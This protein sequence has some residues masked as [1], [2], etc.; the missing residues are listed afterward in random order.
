MNMKQPD[1]EH[2]EEMLPR[3]YDG[4]LTREECRQVEIWMAESEANRRIAGQVHILCLATD[5]MRVR[6]KVN[7]E[8]ALDKVRARMVARKTTW[9]E[10]AQRAAAV[11]FVPLVVALFVQYMN[12]RSP[13]AQM[14]EV[15]TNP[16]V[17]TSVVLP[18][19]TV[20]YLNS[21]SSLSYPSRF[22]GDTREVTLK[23]EAYFDVAKD[24]KKKFIVSTAHR[25]KIEVLGTHFNVEAYGDDAD[26]STTLVE[27]KVCFLY[28]TKNHAGRK[29]V[30][31]PGQ[32]LVYNP[33]REDVQLYATSGVTET[34][35][36]DG[37]I[38]FRNTPLPEALRM[39]EK[40]FNVDFIVRSK[41]LRKNAFTGVFTDQRLERILEYFKISS[42]IRWR[43]L[44]SA[45]IRDERSKIEIY[46]DQ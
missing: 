21:R 14:M 3:Y 25:S 37:K 40:R 33:A 45:D 2:I 34:A 43:Y 1:R 10:W 32:K 39:L 36:K 19:S 12:P 17:T 16:G 29:V 22:E 7:T 11:L 13:V 15:R 41:R 38:I 6:R 26:I 35:W 23:G 9:W 28:E 30:M 31:Q 20:V 8:K 4:K 46:V 5:T 27:G 18:D 44:E 24:K 42:K